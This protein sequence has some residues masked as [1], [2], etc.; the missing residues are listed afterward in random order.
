MTLNPQPG[1]WEIF[2]TWL[3]LGIQSFGGGQATFYLIHKVCIQRGWLDEDEFIRA[4]ALAQISPGINLVKLSVLIGY[5]LRRWPGVLMSMLGLLLPSAILTVLMTAGFSLIQNQPLVRAAMRGI[6][7]ATI[8]LALSMAVQMAWPVL[9]KARREGSINLAANI[10]ILTG[11]ALLLAVGNSSPVLVLILSGTITMFLL[12]I[13]PMR[14]T[15]ANS[16]GSQ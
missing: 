1:L 7:P 12:S 5:K 16:E 8:G 11:A 13:I 6:L 15:P 10:I 14:K 2:F 3:T 9:T 4:W